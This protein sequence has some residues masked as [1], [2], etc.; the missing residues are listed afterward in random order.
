MNSID[1][2]IKTPKLYH[3]T[4]YD[5]AKLIVKNGKMKFGSLPDM[6]DYIESKKVIGIHGTLCSKEDKITLQAVDD[7]LRNI[8]QISLTI[9]RG[10]HG[11]D[12][13]PMWGHYAEKNKG[14]CL[15]FNK[16]RILREAKN[17]MCWS[18]PICYVKRTAQWYITYICV[19][20]DIE[21]YFDKHKEEVFFQKTRDWSYEKEYR[22]IKHNS[23]TIFLPISDCL[24][25]VILN[26]SSHEP[27]DFNRKAKYFEDFHI[28]VYEFV[29]NAFT[30][31]DL[32]LRDNN[33][34]TI[35][36]I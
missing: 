16:K 35:F 1:R 11:F 32:E 29:E 2:F 28:P 4:S 6:N 34:K 31:G 23:D 13:F 9:G 17:L 24:I 27:A 26:S 8:G 10:N 20:E 7:Y 3:Y 19:K 36:K 14:C 33:G 15:V 25:G 30:G 12:I 18:Y 22:I 21:T 5:S